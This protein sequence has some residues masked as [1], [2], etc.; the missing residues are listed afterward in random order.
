MSETDDGKR[1][2]ETEHVAY[3]PRSTLA[4]RGWLDRGYHADTD[5][6][7]YDT[8]NLA[9]EFG[10]RPELEE[11]PSRKQL[12]PYVVVREPGREEIFTLQRRTAQTE[13]RLHH[14]LSIGVGGHLEE[15]KESGSDDPLHAGM[16]RELHEELVVPEDIGV[17]YCGLLNDDADDV[18]RVHLGLVYSVR[19]DREEVAVREVEKM[20]G[21]WRSLGE[22]EEDAERLESWSRLL[23]DPLRDGRV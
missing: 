4:G 2:R 11:D 8:L 6:T 21:T 12:I 3:V 23:L 9:A 20:K 1:R 22:L 17:D 7:A 14:R 10:P 19:L 13:S 5:R 16:K 15:A 18:G